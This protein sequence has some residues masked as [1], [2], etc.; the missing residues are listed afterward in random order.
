MVISGV[1]FKSHPT[2]STVS[3]SLAILQELGVEK[4]YISHLSHDVDYFKH[5]DML[6]NNVEFAYDGLEVEC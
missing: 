3:E 4:G 1:R 5:S 2:H 6:P